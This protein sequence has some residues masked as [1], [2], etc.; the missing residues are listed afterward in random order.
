MR[1]QLEIEEQT[2]TSQPRAHE[3]ADLG[4]YSGSINELLHSLRR[5]SRRG[6]VAPRAQL[7][8]SAS[9]KR[10]EIRLFGGIAIECFGHRDRIKTGA[11]TREW[12][13]AEGLIGTLTKH[14]GSAPEP[15]T[16]LTTDVRA[17]YQVE[18]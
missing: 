2:P 12:T 16:R 10:A 13:S 9:V 14:V 18:L 15:P 7:L 5:A 6:L 3:F 8:S 11:R 4:K 1:K 17:R